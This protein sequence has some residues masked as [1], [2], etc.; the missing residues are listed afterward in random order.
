MTAWRQHRALCWAT[1]SVACVK[2]TAAILLGNKGWIIPWG[3][4]KA[5]LT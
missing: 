2:V 1:P 4:Q 3:V 5:E